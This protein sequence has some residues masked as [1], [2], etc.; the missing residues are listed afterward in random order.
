[1]WFTTSMGLC[2]YDGYNIKIFTSSPQD[3]SSISGN[4][5]Y[6]QPFVDKDGFIWIGT[7]SNGV[8]RYD[9]NTESF[10]RFM[11]D[12]EDPGSIDNNSIWT[13]Y[14]DNSGVIWVGTY[15]GLNEFNAS[16]E[17][18][19]VFR[20]ESDNQEDY[21]NLIYSVLEKSAQQYWICTGKGCYIFDRKAEKFTPFEPESQATKIFNNQAIFQIIQDSDGDLWFATSNG[22]FLYKTMSGDFIHYSADQSDQNKLS[23]PVIYQIIEDPHE[24]GTFWIPSQ[25]GLNRMNKNSGHIEW[26]MNDPKDPFSIGS[27]HLNY[28]YIDETNKLWVTTQ[29]AGVAVTDLIRVKAKNNVD[30]ILMEPLSPDT[31]GYSGTSFLEDKY[32]N[33]WVGTNQKGLYKYDSLLNLISIFDGSPENINF[34][35]NAYIFNLYSDSEDHILVGTF[36]QGLYVFNP[37]NLS[38]LHCKFIKSDTILYDMR[39]TEIMKDRTGILSHVLSLIP[40]EIYGSEQTGD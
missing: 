32:G 13:V 11:H 35:K 16:E 3:S 26:L 2:R 37:D 10:T 36:G 31:T 28:A 1:M 33:I 9:R 29:N 18:F 34:L 5:L 15:S 21:A 40:K 14:Q 38:F 8:C 22:I 39:V 25:W 30:H 7:R 17:T 20:P 27:N 24:H 6:A 4:D 23:G 19:K 12:P